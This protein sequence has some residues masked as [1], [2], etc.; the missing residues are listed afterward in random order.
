MQKNYWRIKCNHTPEVL[1]RI[2]MHFRKRGMTV[3]S[4]NYKNDGNA[5]ASC[6]VEFLELK[7]NADKIYLNLMRT[8]DIESIERMS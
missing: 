2:M 1:D 3:E 5:K 7:D 8:V 6:L 4:V